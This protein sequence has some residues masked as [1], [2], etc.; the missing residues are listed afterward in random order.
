MHLWKTKKK[1]PRVPRSIGRATETPMA[2][3]QLDA[4]SGEIRVFVERMR[5][6]GC[7]SIQ[8]IITAPGPD[9]EDGLTHRHCQGAGNIFAREGAVRRWLQ[10]MEETPMDYGDDDDDLEDV[11]GS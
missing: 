8:V 11:W 3:D 10:D 2:G 9:G 7:D 5:E 1:K 4:V 6:M